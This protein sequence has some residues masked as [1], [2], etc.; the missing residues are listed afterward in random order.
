MLFNKSSLSELESCL[1][2]DPGSLFNIWLCHFF[3][4][5][6]QLLRSSHCMGCVR[7]IYWGRDRFSSLYSALYFSCS[8]SWGRQTLVLLLQSYAK[9][10]GLWHLKQ[11]GRLAA[12]LRLLLLVV[13]AELF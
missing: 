10:P 12:G 8:L 3:M 4:S 7:R 6:C 5:F 11:G 9:W 13:E 2:F 1:R